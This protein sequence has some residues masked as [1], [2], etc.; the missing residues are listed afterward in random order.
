MLFALPFVV[1]F[2]WCKFRILESTG[3]CREIFL[4]CTNIQN[5]SAPIVPFPLGAGGG[6]G[7]GVNGVPGNTGPDLLLPFFW[8]QKEGQHCSK[9]PPVGSKDFCKVIQCFRSVFF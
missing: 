8:G 4:S 1:L 7:G 6:G 5:R 2:K 9:M 3:Y